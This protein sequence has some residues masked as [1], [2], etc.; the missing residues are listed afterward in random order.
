MLEITTCGAIYPYAPMLG[1]K[2]VSLL[3]LSPEVAADYKA[4]YDAPSIISSQMRN[5]PVIRDNSLVYLGT[6]SLYLHGS[7]QYN[8]L[9]LP[10]GI[11]ADDQPEIRYFPVGETTGFGTVQFSAETSRVIDALLSQRNAYKEV[12]SVFGEGTSPKLRKLKSGLRLIGFEPDRLLR[13][14]QQRL[15]Y[16]SPMF[17][18][19]RDWLMERTTSLPSYLASP[20]RFRGST[21]KI[22]EFWRSRWLAKRLDHDSSFFALDQ[23]N[24][25]LL[26]TGANVALEAV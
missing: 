10:A 15:I 26:P 6:T 20:D 3:M 19:A 24:N 9:T 23:N 14:Q 18:E 5:K 2:L 22:A 17:K 12:N 7:S 4:T 16:G 25:P 1:G 21:H 8:R 13:H 11:I